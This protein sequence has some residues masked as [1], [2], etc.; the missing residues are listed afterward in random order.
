[1][2][3]N[4]DLLYNIHGYS[5]LRLN[6]YSF[7][8]LY[9]FIY[10]EYTKKG[11]ILDTNRAIETLLDLKNNKEFNLIHKTESNYDSRFNK[12][13]GTK[14]HIPDQHDLDA[15]MKYATRFLLDE[16]FSFQDYND[17][18]KNL[19]CYEFHS[20]NP[21]PGIFLFRF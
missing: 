14:E 12:F 4:L 16:K 2:Y 6:W 9:R 19:S 11:F 21:R 13:I 10:C 15:N 20:P 1:M 7:G 8:M 18:I 17:S 3:L 5:K